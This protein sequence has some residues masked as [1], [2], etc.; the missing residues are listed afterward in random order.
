MQIV[1]KARNSELIA[2]IYK[3]FVSCIDH[4]FNNLEYPI[5]VIALF[6]IAV[7]EFDIL[8]TLP[9]ALAIKKLLHK[10]S[11]AGR[12]VTNGIEELIELMVSVERVK[13]FL[14]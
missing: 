12:S 14:N 10:L 8:L 9:T 7:L 4:T 5:I 2:F 3:S 11:R 1:N 13:I 6:S